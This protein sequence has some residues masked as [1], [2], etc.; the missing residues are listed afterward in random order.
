MF[1]FPL[2][3]NIITTPLEIIGYELESRHKPQEFGFCSIILFMVEGKLSSSPDE[4]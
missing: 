2:I 3:C 1:N 4:D